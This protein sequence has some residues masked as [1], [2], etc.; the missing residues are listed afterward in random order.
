MADGEGRMRESGG[1]EEG[2]EET[3]ER[4]RDASAGRVEVE[5]SRREW[6]MRRPVRREETS[7]RRDE[8]EEGEKGEWKEKGR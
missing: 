8:L 5:R 6:W 7:W 3:E 1:G 2:E 4:E